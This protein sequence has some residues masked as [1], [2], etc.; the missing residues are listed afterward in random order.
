MDRKEIAWR[1][2]RLLDDQY[3]IVRARFD[4]FPRPAES[5]L[6]DLPGFEPGFSCVPDMQAVLDLRHDDWD[7]RLFAA[8][9]AI[10]DDRLSF[11]DLEDQHLGDPIEWHTDHSAGI[12]GPMRPCVFVDYRDFSTFGDCKLVW[13][14]N[15]HHQ[16]VVLGRAFQVSNDIRYAEK[17]VNLLVDWL[18]ANQFGYGMNWKSPLEL[19]IRLINWVWA[20]DLIRDSGVITD[21][22][23]HD[24]Q[25]A[26][27]RSMWDIQRKYSQGSS[28]NNHLIGEAAGVF[29]AA[30]YFDHL[31]GAD[32]L[33]E[34]ARAILEREIVAQSFTDGCTREHAFGYQLF[35]IQF[36]TIVATVARH[37]SAPMSESFMTRLHAS[38]QFIADL[39]RD[40]GRP[41]N[42]GDADDGYVLDLGDKPDAPAGLI[43]VGAIL[44]ED[45]ELQIVDASES[46]CW[47]FGQPALTDNPPRRV[48][49]SHAYEESGYF[50]LR[51]GGRNGKPA[52]RVFF[53]CAEL[54]YGSIAAHGHADCLSFTLSA[55][56]HDVLVDA[57]TY[58]YFSYPEWREY[59]RST[60][61]HNTLSID[62]RSQSVS[63]GPFLW[64]HRANASLLDWQYSGDATSVCGEHDGFCHDEVAVIHR[65]HLQLDSHDGKLTVNDTVECAEAH[66][67][68]RFFHLAPDCTVEVA[69]SNSIEIRYPGGTIEFRHDSG[70]AEI[71]VANDDVKLGWV[72]D[73]YHVRK[74]SSCIVLHDEVTATREFGVTFVPH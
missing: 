30:S 66:D 43:S 27:H 60:D 62:G 42:S 61:A 40:T 9:D 58:D 28:A 56:N 44:H 73:G 16:L 11:F 52:I 26:V 2:K 38:Y 50:I 67:V 19:G 31:P 46:C 29:V 24:L 64:S 63:T 7:A 49:E 37:R 12:N 48:A 57:G 5:G 13:E 55:D 3:D 70:N 17:V 69:S 10:F 25:V 22:S 71:I 4:H 59:F 6:V 47:L 72:S 32:E 15:R 65:R 51:T 23:W 54:G 41:P 35:V 39:C 1:I 8:A 14:P 74:P 20:I 45:P 68:R 21:E 18:S 36:H 34:E 53:D 33:A